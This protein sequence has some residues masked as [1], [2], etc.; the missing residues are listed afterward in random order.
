MENV[1]QL[2]ENEVLIFL[3]IDGVLV[4][5]NSLKFNKSSSKDRELFDKSCVKI[6][7]D[8]LKKTNCKVIISSSWRI[9]RSLEDLREIFF[10]NKIETLPFDKT[11]PSAT[12]RR[13]KEILAWMFNNNIN[14]QEAKFL[15][16]DDEI[17]DIVPVVELKNIFHVR[18]SLKTGLVKKDKKI[19]FKKINAMLNK[20]EITNQNELE[21]NESG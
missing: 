16:I 4:T 17:Y 6:L 18:G 21:I 12:G 1:I 2:G 3:D 10:K 8:V 14:P 20:K 9:G 11:P 7:N 5:W 13:G 15:V 19:I